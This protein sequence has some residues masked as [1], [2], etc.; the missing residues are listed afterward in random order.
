[1]SPLKSKP[2]CDLWREAWGDREAWRLRLWARTGSEVIFCPPP[3]APPKIFQSQPEVTCSGRGPGSFLR[4][5]PMASSSS[6]C[7]T[8]GGPSPKGALGPLRKVSAPPLGAGGIFIP[9]PHSSFIHPETAVPAALRDSNQSPSREPVG[10][11]RPPG[12]PCAAQQGFGF[13]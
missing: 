1:M 9:C 6:G 7:L 13:H 12:K 11:D 8:S 4:G 10:G 3:P 2:T 5:M